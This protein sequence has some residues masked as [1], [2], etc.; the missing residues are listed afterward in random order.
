MHTFRLLVVSALLSVL[1]GCAA[2]QGESPTLFDLGTP[3]ENVSS[4]RLEGRAISVAAVEAPP[5]LDNEYMYYRLN[6]AE[7][8]Q[9]RAYAGSRWTMSPAQ[10]LAQ[11]V[12]Q[13]IAQAGGVALAEADLAAQVPILRIQLDDFSQH[14]AA[15]ETNTGRIALRATL[16]EGRKV[17]GQR[18]F[19]EQ[20]PAPSASAAGGAQALAQATD[21]V[22][23]DLIDWLATLP[24]T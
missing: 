22:L 3:E 21:D 13:R 6:Y 12:R 23:S 24:K 18:T 20:V 5:W 16:F 11:R 17:I 4:T 15:P 19:V 7:R 8:Q 14:F 2:V 10:L 9:P 1:T